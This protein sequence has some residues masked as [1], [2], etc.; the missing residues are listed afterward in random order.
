MVWKL[1]H[2]NQ[3]AQSAGRVSGQKASGALGDIALPATQQIVKPYISTTG[4]KIRRAQEETNIVKHMIYIGKAKPVRKPPRHTPPPLVE[5][6][7]LLVEGMKKLNAVG[8]RNTAATFQRL[9]QA[10]LIGIFPKHCIINLD[11]IVFGG[12][13]G[14]YNANLKLMLDCLRETGLTPILKK[15][16]FL[17]RAVT[18]L[19]YTFLSGRM[20]V[21]EDRTIQVK[22]R[23]AL[24]NQMELCNF[25]V[26][27][28]HY[29][30]F[31]KSLAKITSPPY[32]LIE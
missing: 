1:S 26:L 24:T 22:T 21:T 30:S 29:S 31:V 4:F 11:Y 14:E 16:H 19:E 17:Q 7:Y 20:A 2:K 9:M 5:E 23:P 32:N 28:N 25:P 18:F 12:D 10:A 13:I 8:L 3:K 6:A 27:A 15:C